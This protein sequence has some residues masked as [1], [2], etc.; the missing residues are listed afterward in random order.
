[1]P[2]PLDASSAVTV[3]LPI[4]DWYERLFGKRLV[5]SSP[6][7]TNANDVVVFHSA[8][9]P[10]V[11]NHY[12]RTSFSLLLQLPTELRLKI[13]AHLLQDVKADDW[14]SCHYRA[15]P[16]SIIFTCKLMYAEAR[17]LAIEACTFPYESLPE[18]RDMIKSLG[19]VSSI[20][21]SPSDKR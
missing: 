15:T 3:W 19:L 16:A 14:M 8:S 17:G 1:M 11:L 6:T 2:P 13:L 10:T 5:T 21:T 7:F 4:S 9:N 18:Y 20:S 12:N